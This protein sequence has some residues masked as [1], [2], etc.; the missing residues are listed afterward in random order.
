MDQTQSLKEPFELKIGDSFAA[1]GREEKGI[2]IV[3]PLLSSDRGTVYLSRTLKERLPIVKRKPYLHFILDFSEGAKSVQRPYR[4]EIEKIVRKLPFKITN[5]KITL[6]NYNAKTLNWDDPWQ[7][8]VEEHP[9]RGGFFL[10][11]VLKSVLLEHYTRNDYTYP[12]IIVLSSDFSQAIFTEGLTN[13]SFTSPES[14][15]Y[16]ELTPSGELIAHPFI[17]AQPGMPIKEEVLYTLNKEVLAWPSVQEH[18]AFVRNDSEPSVVL[19]PGKDLTIGNNQRISLNDQWSTGLSLQ[20][21]WRDHLIH[22]SKDSI[23]WP[24]LVGLSQENRIL[25]PATSFIVLEN[26]AQWE[27][28]KRK[29]KKTMSGKNVFD[30]GPD[31]DSRQ[32]SEPG[33]LILLIFLGFIYIV[34]KKRKRVA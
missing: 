30:L 27:I 7:S 15:Y 4:S 33:F 3:T 14:D 23:A 8:I 18:L 20:G 29:Q 32:M 1:I 10:E 24:R 22:P 16:Y 19:L 11:Y 6:A 21:M 9:M 2:D 31:E 13:Y 5:T 28:L 17:D 34:D 25:N 26:Q 12:V